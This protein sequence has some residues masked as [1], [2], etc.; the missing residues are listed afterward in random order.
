MDMK[1]KVFTACR[2]SGMTLTE[3]G[4]QMGLSQQNFSTRL[5]VG[6]FKQED[7]EKMAE[8]MGCEYHSVFLFP[9]GNRVE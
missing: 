6:K 9:N 7:Y 5:K 2:M 4:S 8:I 3:L 1:Q